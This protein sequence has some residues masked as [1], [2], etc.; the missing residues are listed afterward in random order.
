MPCPAAHAFP[1]CAC[2]AP[3]RQSRKLAGGCMCLPWCSTM[4]ACWLGRRAQALLQLSDPW[5]SAAGHA[6][7]MHWQA[8]PLRA[9][10][11]CSAPTSLDGSSCPRVPRPALA[12]L[13]THGSMLGPSPPVFPVPPLQCMVQKCGGEIFACYADTSCR[14]ALNCLNNCHFNDQVPC[15][16]FLSLHWIAADEADLGD[17]T[18]A[19]A[20]LLKCRTQ[21]LPVHCS[22]GCGGSCLLKAFARLFFGT[23]CHMAGRGHTRTM[24]Q[25]FCNTGWTGG[26]GPFSVGRCRPHVHPALLPAAPKSLPLKPPWWPTLLPL[27]LPLQLPGGRSVPCSR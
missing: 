25:A 15:T 27:I 7:A 16:T 5:P 8:G 10:T 13:V 11:P 12:T 22:C 23:A 26:I 20:C 6:A 4:L 3:T 24:R 17:V 9:S 2:F 1:C 14:T 19:P 18:K 21:Q